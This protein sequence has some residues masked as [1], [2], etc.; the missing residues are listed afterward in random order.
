MKEEMDYVMVQT[1]PY[2][3]VRMFMLKTIFEQEN[4]DHLI[5]LLDSLSIWG[6]SDWKND[7]HVAWEFEKEMASKLKKFAINHNMKFQKGNCA[8]DI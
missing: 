1:T 5:L 8:F 3:T 4:Q 2:N 6:G 7:T